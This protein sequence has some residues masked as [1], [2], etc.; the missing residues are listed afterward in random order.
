M[1]ETAM[2]DIRVIDCNLGVCFCHWNIIVLNLFRISDFEIRDFIFHKM[3]LQSNDL[4]TRDLI[5]G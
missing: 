3:L 4:W 1:T 5:V 2:C